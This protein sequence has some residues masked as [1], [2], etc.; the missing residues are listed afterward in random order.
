MS[1]DAGFWINRRKQR[2]IDDQADEMDRLAVELE[3]TQLALKKAREQL[4][5]LK[6]PEYF[7]EVLDG[8]IVG[9]L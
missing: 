4:A 6:A 1:P 2:T 5:T 3:R 9:K 8:I 7:F